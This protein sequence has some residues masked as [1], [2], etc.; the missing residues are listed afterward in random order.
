MTFATPGLHRFAHRTNR[1]QGS[2]IRE[3]LKATQYPEVISFAGGLPAPELFPTQELGR[4][5]N[6]AIARYGPAMVQYSLTEGIPQ[7]RAW[8]AARLNRVHGTAFSPDDVVITGGSQQAL[9]LFAKIFLDPGDTVVVEN[10][11]YL[12]ALQAFDAY[13]PTFLTLETDDHGI[14][15]EALSAAL[16]RAPAMPKFLYVIP[17]YQN[18]TGITLTLE[19]R[20]AIAAI[21]ERF[22]LPVF[23]DNPYG[24]LSFDGHEITP[25]I[26]LG[27]GAPI[28]YSGTGSKIVA[29]GLRVAWM[30]I[31]D[32]SIRE[33]IVPAKQG[34]DLHTGSFA[35]YVFHEYATTGDQLERHIERIRATYAKRRDA[36]AQAL[37]T[38]MP[39]HVQYTLPTGGMFF[40]ATVDASI[41][42]DELFVRAAREK[43][44]FVPGR[45]FYPSRDRGDGLRLNFSNSD[46]AKIATGIERLAHVIREYHPT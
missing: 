13:E 29:P 40:W 1:M 24:E 11:S 28:T 7:M 37:R 38:H 46:E 4:A 15:P 27:S 39:A 34:M 18:P 14:L 43:V 35:Q 23:E 19:R 9:D 10:P 44:V 42:T 12:G 3:I 5:T 33:K 45:S 22:Q 8:V 25:M 21:C 32:R 6:A 17:S 16:T 20:R 41:D 31:P 2:A 36:M 30:V 26:A